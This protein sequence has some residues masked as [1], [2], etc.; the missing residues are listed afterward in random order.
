[1]R[2]MRLAGLLSWAHK[3]AVTFEQLSDL[4]LELDQLQ[5]T[6][7]TL[8]VA[9][10]VNQSLEKRRL[11][12]A[13]TTV[14]A[15][16]AC[17]SANAYATS[18][19]ASL[20]IDSSLS[21]ADSSVR[22]GAAASALALLPAWVAST[23]CVS[24]GF[25]AFAGDSFSEAPFIRVQFPHCPSSI[26]P[27][28]KPARNDLSVFKGPTD[29]AEQAWQKKCEEYRLNETRT[30][31]Q[32]FDARATEVREKLAAYRPVEPE[33]TCLLDLLARLRDSDETQFAVVITDGVETCLPSFRGPIA[34]PLTHK[35]IVMVLI[36]PHKM[37]KSLSPG[38]Y[39][40]QR[41]DFWM[42]LAPWLKAII[43]APRLS[44]NTFGPLPNPEGSVIAGDSQ[45]KQR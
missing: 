4:E 8:A 39:F 19:C 21:V 20:W 45:S 33:R 23:S 30:Y 40:S 37:Q 29:A 44:E 6:C 16:L 3:H 43:P 17:F 5:Q 31:K 25:Y 38:I 32:A 15:L 12:L 14:V 35:A 11:A 27:I 22:E 18:E 7:V 9:Y 36:S 26:C 1:M 42:T 28:P 13:A 41:R 24:W 2:M 10:P 34:G